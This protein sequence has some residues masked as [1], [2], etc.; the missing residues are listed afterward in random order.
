MKEY[1]IMIDNREIKGTG[2]EITKALK[3]KSFMYNEMSMEEFIEQIQFNT[4]KLYGIGISINKN[5]SLE[6]QCESLVEQLI[7]N[8]L[9]P[10]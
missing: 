7:N 6:K 1:K 9:L 3:E 2:I 5:E 8:G 10:S 4:W